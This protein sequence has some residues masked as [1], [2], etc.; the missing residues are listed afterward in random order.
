MDVE[1]LI[2]YFIFYHFI[3]QVFYK[4]TDT[5]FHS[6]LNSRF[7]EMNA[8][9]GWYSIEKLKF[10]R[11]YRRIEGDVNPMDAS[12]VVLITGASSGIGRATAAHLA[13]KG[14][15]VFGTSRQPIAPTLDGFEMLQLDVTD[16]QSVRACVDTVLERAGRL[17]V[18]VNNAGV[19]M[20]GAIEE[21]SIEDA[22]WIFDTNF[23]GVMRMTQAVLPHMRSRNS[24]QLINI[25]SAL[26]LAAWP[27]E[28]LY[29]ASKYALEGYTL[30]LRYEMNLFNI[31]V[32]SVQPGF[33]RTD[34]VKQQRHP[35]HPI[36]DYDKARNRM[37]ALGKQWAEEAPPPTPVAKT[38]QKIIES[39]SPRARYAVGIEA[40]LA[41]PLSKILPE[42]LVI[43]IARRLLG[44]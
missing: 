23:F 7:P 32:S 31:K 40:I 12:K 43:A 15:R 3:A 10:R 42:R 2:E 13:L 21:T 28:T 20:M 34:M 14:Y 18:L 39:R 4:F 1:I 17:D 35:S 26:G 11:R 16:N 36:A 44:V 27:F 5:A 8:R 29:C 37:I 22:Q 25:S 6:P 24:G 41:P 38:V 30:G 19:D 33:Y 9:S